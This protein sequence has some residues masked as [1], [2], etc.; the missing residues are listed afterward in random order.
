MDDLLT[1]A[2]P[3]STISPSLSPLEGKPEPVPGE[4][5]KSEAVYRGHG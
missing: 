3:I 2:V 4:E 5:H 1:L